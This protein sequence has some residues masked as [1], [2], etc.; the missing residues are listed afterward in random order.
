MKNQLS[1]HEVVAIALININKKTFSATFEEIA[2]FI[3]QRGLYT[4]RKG[5][6]TLAKQVMLR[7]TKANGAY[8]YLFH[9]VDDRS[10][11]LKSYPLD[12]K[13]P[14]KKKVIVD[15]VDLSAYTNEKKPIAKLKN[16]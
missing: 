6:I 1:L 8:S 3:K 16:G 9:Q 14:A 4:E 12:K 13:K 5:N 11:Q 10:I 2:D 15:S 7:S